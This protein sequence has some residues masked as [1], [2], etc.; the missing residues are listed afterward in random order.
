MS[1]TEEPLIVEEKEKL[2]SLFKLIAKNHSQTDLFFG[3][4][5]EPARTRAKSYNEENCTLIL[6]PLEPISQIQNDYLS[7]GLSKI[8]GL[9]RGVEFQINQPSIII[10]ND[11]STVLLALPTKMQYLQ[12]R[13]CFR[14]ALSEQ[15]HLYSNDLEIPLVGNLADISFEGAR[16]VIENIEKN[17]FF[18]NPSPLELTIKT[19][20]GEALVITSNIRNIEF[21]SEQC[22]LRLGLKFGDME[23]RQRNML[24]ALVLEQQRAALRQAAMVQSS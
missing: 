12:R 9:C 16:F 19:E 23:G 2:I 8:Q 15:G 18:E 4:S 17:P 10:D 1:N 20:A 7:E 21:D 6:S 22:K 11:H 24:E 13:L 3:A 14:V 5:D